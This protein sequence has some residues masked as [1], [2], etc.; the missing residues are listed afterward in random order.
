MNENNENAIPKIIHYCWFGNNEKPFIVKRCIASWKKYC[1][2]YEIVEWNEQNFD[3]NTNLYVKN[4][5]INKKWA[6]VTDY[7]RLFAIYNCGGFYLDTDVELI[8]SLDQFRNFKNF[9]ATEDNTYIN[10]GLG[11]GAC[12]KSK[13][14]YE[15]LKSYDKLTFF[16]NGNLDLKPCTLRNSELIEKLLSKKISDMINI[17]ENDL[18]ILSNDYFCP[19]NPLT[20][21]MNK[22]SN[23]CGIHWFCGSWRKKSVNIQ[24]KILR[25]FKR[26]IGLDNFYK[27][28]KI[29]TRSRNS[30]DE[31]EKIVGV[32]TLYDN[33]NYGNRLQS[34][35]TFS[36]LRKNKIQGE[37]LIDDA[38]NFVNKLKYCMKKIIKCD[39]KTNCA[40]KRLSNF[41]EFSSKI[42]YCE[43]LYGMLKS[44]IYFKIN[45]KI[46]AYL[47]GSDQVWN[48]GQ[49]GINDKY[50]LCFEKNKPKISF[51]ASFGRSCF[52]KKFSS[53]TAKELNSFNYI[54]VREDAGKKIV[55]EL[56][57]RTD[58]EVLI[59]PTMLLTADEWD[60][61]SK[62][63]TMLKNDK[64]ILNYFLG[65]LSDERRNEI[66]RVAKENNCEVINILDK[67][68]P[69]YE[70]GPSEFLYLEKNAFL[71][72]TDSFH[73]SVFGILYNTP[74]L[75]FEREDNNVSMNSR[76]DTL[77]SKFKLE[78][79]R[80]KGKITKKD[81]KCD[82]TEAYNILDK[83]RIKSMNF[84]KKA[85]DIK[86]SDKNE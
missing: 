5:Y 6:F 29:I 46:S 21:K 11:F 81:L 86:D 12:K 26:I 57:G 33:N 83:E 54:S 73:S 17:Y 30:T 82:Y 39:H 61:V 66:N 77:L 79:R 75:V 22:T 18:L 10:T 34:Y 59:D 68:S 43:C 45:K 23:T 71:I 16:I 32:V 4:A 55:E 44:H 3:I 72:C 60:K 38:N 56:T 31:Y 1:P 40:D 15:L 8:K 64:Y 74:F 69:F 70:C 35:A 53:R 67:E 47:V 41:L 49:R 27:I 14:I 9:M 7:V 2:D 80:Y 25:P 65:N 84:L 85:L 52:P 19:F 42:P 78:D 20:G 24:E 36:I 62:K 37:F 13:I 48:V 28:K 50:L 76:L 63:P 58:V 51:A